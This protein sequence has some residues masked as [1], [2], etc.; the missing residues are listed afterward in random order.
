M[1]RG[2]GGVGG[3]VDLIPEL[4]KPVR[5]ATEGTAWER[6]GGGVT[7]RRSPNRRGSNCSIAAVSA[8]GCRSGEWVPSIGG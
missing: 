3:A 5:G 1:I 2:T 7:G 6:L 8:T 4:G